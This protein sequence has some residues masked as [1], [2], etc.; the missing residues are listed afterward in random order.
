MAATIRLAADARERGMRMKVI[1]PQGFTVGAKGE[2]WIPIMPGTDSAVLLTIANLIVNEI[3]VYDR[4][5]IRHKT[6]ASYLVAPDRVFARDQQTGKPLLFDE[7]DGTVKP[8]DDP[9]LKQ[10]AIEGKY[11]VD[12]ME[13]QP[14]FALIKEHL[15]QYNPAWAAEVSTVPEETIRRLARELVEEAKIGSF[16]EIDGVKVPYRPACAVGY[17]G[18]QTHS[19]AFHQYASLMQL[20]VLL[21]NLDVCGGLLGS[22]G[23][24]SLGYPE[25][26]GYRYSPYAGPDG[27]LMHTHW[28]AG[29]GPWEVHKVGPGTAVHFRDIFVHSMGNYYPLGEDWEELW[30]N[31]GRPFEPEVYFTYGG[32]SVMNMMNPEA[33]GRALSKIPFSFAF[34]PFHNETTEGF[35]DIVLPETHY[36][37]TLDPSCAFMFQIA[38]PIG[39]NKWSI[40]IRVPVSEPRGETRDTYSFYF[41]LADRVGI[42][43]K[44][45]EALNAFYSLSNR[46]IGMETVPS[47]IEPEEKITETELAD[48]VLKHHFGTDKG[49]EWFME[50]GFITWEKK[51]E[52]A[53]WRWF[54]DARAPFYH[55]RFERE[56]EQ[57]KTN[58][59]KIGFH[60]NWDQYT[61][62]ITYFPSVT[63]TELPPDSEYDLLVIS[64]RDPLLTHRFT[65]HNPYIDE[66]AEH[67]PFTYNIAMNV[68][69]AH[70]KGIKD[71]E[72]ISL[73]NVWGYKITGTVKLTRL[74][75]PKVVA[76]VG[77]GSFARGMPISRGKGVNPNALIKGD[78]YHMCPV[79]GSAEPLVRVKAYRTK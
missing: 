58:A 52:E 67:N 39:L 55:E 57:V 78:Q 68:E 71:G 77:L 47:I 13:C 59:E 41:D 4:E 53:Y 74:I 20:N 70:Q 27:M 2:E 11:A 29:P 79:T 63:Y 46:M 3:G 6:N 16:T 17:R 44:F 54:V 25:T 5:F 24:K 56:R 64:Y 19:N 66:M 32:N 22:G 15:K 1:D 50:H 10:P 26:G 37:E 73:E 14:G 12:G 28:V 75:H 40:H 51:P 36:L 76:A 49:L 35:C 60:L 45:N 62:L 42:R 43:S 34:Q 21:G 30:N 38:F 7:A 61:P 69:T 33:A 23:I 18:I 9:T 65:V 72:V 31:A 48:K 8:Y